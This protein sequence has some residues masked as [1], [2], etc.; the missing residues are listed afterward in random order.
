MYSLYY[1]FTWLFVVLHLVSLSILYLL[2]VDNPIF[3]MNYVF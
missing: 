2:F 3:K 1:L